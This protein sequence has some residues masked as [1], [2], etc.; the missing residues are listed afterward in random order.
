MN[1]SQQ[2]QSHNQHKIVQQQAET[3]KNFFSILG[4]VHWILLHSKIHK[5][6]FCSDVEALFFPAILHKCFRI[7]YSRDKQP[8]G[9]ICWARVN[10]V[11]HM[12]LHNQ[13]FRLKPEEWNSG[14][15][16]WI[17]EMVAPFGG[18]KSMLDELLDGIFQDDIVFVQGKNEKG[19]VSNQKVFGKN[20]KARLQEETQL[21]MG[22]SESKK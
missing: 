1:P 11:V 20:R 17:M 16:I 6:M 9:V 18:E 7:F 22:N 3:S 15:N 2:L 12:R 21:L 14:A 5:F 10:D 4:E 13:A 8:V 19:F